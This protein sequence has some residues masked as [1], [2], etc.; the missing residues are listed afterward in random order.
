MLSYLN[1]LPS[2]PVY[3]GPY[4]VGSSEHEIPISSLSLPALPQLQASKLT[5][6]KF[7]LFYPTTSKQSSYTN[8][9]NYGIP[10][11][12]D[13][14]RDHLNAYLRLSGIKPWLS[15]F[16]LSS[17]FRYYL[18]TTQIPVHHNAPLLFNGAKVPTLIFSH[19]LVGNMNTHS[20]LLGELASHGVFCLALDHR[21]GSG[22]LT[23]LRRTGSEPNG[24]AATVPTEV[25]L[26]NPSVYYKPITLKIKPGMHEARD[27]QLSIRLFEL[28]AAYQALEVMNGGQILPNLAGEGGF[29][30]PKGSLDMSP[31]NVIWAGHSFGGTSTVQFVKSVF[32]SEAHGDD[33]KSPLLWQEPSSSLKAQVTPHSPVVLL[34]PWFL[35]LRS[36]KTEM[37]L[38]R[39]L[40]CHE[41][42]IGKN[43]ARTVVLMCSEF[44]YHWPECH[45]HMPVV[46]GA[47][48]SNVKVQT[49]EEYREEIARYKDQREY[50]NKSKEQ[51]AKYLARAETEKDPDKEGRSQVSEEQVS[52][53]V[54]HETTHVTHSDFGIMFPWMVWW[55]TGQRR[56]VLATRNIARSI[57]AETGVDSAMQ[58]ADDPT[59]EKVQLEHVSKLWT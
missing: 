37:L 48:P 23:T 41:A 51:R 42:E 30:L 8:S 56:P 9:Q 27:E 26:T 3:T 57:L 25:G 59:V 11:L 43:S 20:A 58:V 54:L 5:T 19:G 10:W 17:P 44:A 28:S 6:L 21:D 55:F 14:Q 34:D 35:P 33:A 53:Y 16:L 12:Q 39:P 13:P 32:Y 2:L 31:G 22:P 36:P 18:S 40:P 45:S 52:M 4:A 24:D 50:M 49:I 38:R 29:T 15:D 1:P 46:A 47:N 7:R